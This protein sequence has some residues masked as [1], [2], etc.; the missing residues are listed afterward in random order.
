MRIEIKG[1]K[2][3]RQKGSYVKLENQGIVFLV[4]AK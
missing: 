1:K 2:K 3:R 4:L